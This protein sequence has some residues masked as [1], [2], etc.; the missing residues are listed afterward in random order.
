MAV[1]CGQS[2]ADATGAGG[3]LAVVEVR[4]PNFEVLY[5]DLCNRKLNANGS[6]RETKKQRVHDEIRRALTIARTATLSTQILTTTLSD[7]TSKAA[8]L[9][10]ELHSLIDIA[11]AHLQNRVPDSDREILASDVSHFLSN[12]DIIGDALSAQL[13]LVATS[14]CTISDPLNP[15]STSSLLTRATALQTSATETLPADLQAAHMHLTHSFS[16]LLST[17]T[18]LLTLAIKSLEQTQQGALARHTKSTA[19]LLH[20]RATLLGL[21]AKIHSVSHAPPAE[22][23]AALREFKKKQGSGE[24]ALRDREALAKR[25]LEL[26][27]RAGAKGMRDLAARKV[28]LGGEVERVEGEV[29]KLERGG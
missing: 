14:L 20:T 19:E 24:R 5:K 16:T 7:L 2:D 25:E 28:W 29:G 12:L 1:D 9:P 26:Y 3:A 18:T 15:P 10:Q 11:A 8:D 21:Q 4:N 17:H 22:F 13:H 6:T 23:L 27:E